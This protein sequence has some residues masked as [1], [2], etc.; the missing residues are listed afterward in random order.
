[1][2]PLISVIIP[3]FNR[4]TFTEKAVRSVLG[5]TGPDFEILLIDDGSSDGTSKLKAVDPRLRYFF[6]ENRGVAPAR[7]LGLRHARGEWIAFLDSDDYWLPRK[8]ETQLRFH[9]ENPRF[10]VS[11][12]QEIW[13]R[14]GK[15]VNPKN[16]HRKP[17]GALFESSLP[18]CI[19]SP[20]CVMLH[21]DVLEKTGGFDERFTVCEDYEL[22][23]RVTLDFEIGLVDKALTVKTGGHADQLSK[24]YWGMD[25]FRILAIEKT[26]LSSSLGAEQKNACLRELRKK[27]RIYGNGCLKR[28]RGEEARKFLDLA[29]KYEGQI[30]NPA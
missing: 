22:W 9:S 18:L 20:S 2:T 27:C 16:R 4:K 28:N 10:R 21:R 29:S 23:L 30:E 19:I 26:L 1:M 15:R 8:L 12:T 11:Q 7:N 13:I 25:R 3:T 6:Q 5:Q 24:R 17:A 14:N